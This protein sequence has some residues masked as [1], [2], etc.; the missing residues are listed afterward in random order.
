MT[1]RLS[2]AAYRVGLGTPSFRASFMNRWAE[3][4]PMGRVIPAKAGI[5]LLHWMKR[6]DS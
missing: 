1:A 3:A 4:H 2:F 5:K 6:F